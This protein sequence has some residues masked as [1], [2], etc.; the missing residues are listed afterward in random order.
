M[1]MIKLFDKI[2]INYWYNKN[3]DINIMNEINRWNRRIFKKNI[4]KM[5]SRWFWNVFKMLL[6]RFC[7]ENDE[8]NYSLNIMI[9]LK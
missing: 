7:N 2:L 3:F 8:N 4:S 5:I 9:F 1:R 6:K